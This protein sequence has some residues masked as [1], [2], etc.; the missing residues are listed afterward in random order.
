MLKL[1][2]KGI[3]LNS[4][5]NPL[6]KLED[7]EALENF[8]TWESEF[9]QNFKCFE[10]A[11]A[12]ISGQRSGADWPFPQQALPIPKTENKI[13][14]GSMSKDL[15]SSHCSPDQS[16]SHRHGERDCYED[17]DGEKKFYRR[18]QTFL[19]CQTHQWEFRSS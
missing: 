11:R 7:N 5:R 17:P 13:S 10:D 14:S 4:S 19:R 16:S 9:D 2:I 18:M 12:V 15:Q 1:V 8:S 3:P 6:E